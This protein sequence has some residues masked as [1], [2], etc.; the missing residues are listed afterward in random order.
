MP[1]QRQADTIMIRESYRAAE[2]SIKHAL[3]T[4]NGS[5]AGTFL[6]SS[7]HKTALRGICAQLRIMESRV[8]FY[9]RDD[10][11]GGTE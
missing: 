3:S 8:P 10:E 4:L 9:E 2:A 11:K 6:W 1:T 5:Y 7:A